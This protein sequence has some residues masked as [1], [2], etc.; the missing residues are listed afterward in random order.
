VVA[1]EP[2]VYLACASALAS[3]TGVYLHKMSEVAPAEAA[4]DPE[5]GARLWAL[6]QS[7]LERAQR[8]GKAHS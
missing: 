7:L 4:L 8:S 1:A 5:N 6:N 3:R 2:V